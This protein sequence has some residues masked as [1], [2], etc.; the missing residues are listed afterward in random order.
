MK[1]ILVL[2]ATMA[3]ATLALGQQYKWVDKDG[4]VQYGDAPPPGVSATRLKGAGAA[5][6]APA[7]EPQT[8]GP[9]TPAEQEAGFRK[10]QLDAEKERE[11]QAQAEK[12]T[13]ARQEN[14]ARAQQ[15]LRTLESGQRISRTDAK[16][17][18]Y[19]LDDAQI[20]QETVQARQAV[21][22]SC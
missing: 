19:I 6:A 10:R 21:K 22:A 17:E 11:K 18:R 14:C 7:A 15:A 1:R 20:A 3:F 8:K 4:R 13:L 12:Q 5:P 16:G 2:A 9:L